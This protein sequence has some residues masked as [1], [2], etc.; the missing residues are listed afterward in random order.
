MDSAEIWKARREIVSSWQNA[1]YAGTDEAWKKH[2]KKLKVWAKK[3]NAI[4][5]AA[6][7]DWALER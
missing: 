2:R 1:F 4:S 5:P 7:E 6:L 3:M